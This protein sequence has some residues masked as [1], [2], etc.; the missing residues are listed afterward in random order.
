MA[1]FS[2]GLQG[3]AVNFAERA[4]HDGFFRPLFSAVRAE[5]PGHSRELS[6]RLQRFLDS[7]RVN[8]RTDDDKTLVLATRRAAD[9]GPAAGTSS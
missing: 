3:L 2:D 5:P 9:A 1:L 4:P 7:P 8:A 6:D